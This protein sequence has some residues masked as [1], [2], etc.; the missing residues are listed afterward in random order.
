MLKADKTALHENLSPYIIISRSVILRM[1]NIFEKLCR[2]NQNTHFMFNYMLPGNHLE[3]YGR[4]R[5][6]TGDSIL[7]W[8]LITC[9]IIKATDTHPEYV[10]FSALPKQKWLHERALVL[11]YV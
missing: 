9:L 4:A 3:N 2:Q 8:M 7:R 11:R 6:D 1:R 5:Q 10:M